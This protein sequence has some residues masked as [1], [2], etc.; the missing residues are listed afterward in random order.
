MSVVWEISLLCKQRCK[1]RIKIHITT[2]SKAILACQCFTITQKR[3]FLNNT[4]NA[5]QLLIASF[6]LFYSK[7]LQTSQLVKQH[8]RLP[9]FRHHITNFAWSVIS[10][11][12][13][14]L[15]LH[16]PL[17]V[18]ISQPFKEIRHKKLSQQIFAAFIVVLIRPVLHKFLLSISVPANLG[19]HITVHQSTVPSPPRSGLFTRRSVFVFSPRAELTPSFTSLSLFCFECWAEISSCAI[20]SSSQVSRF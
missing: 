12:V 6:L 20:T 4:L 3:S 17:I 19:Q 11:L 1:L 13:T 5:I 15:S 10:Q 9:R 7:F 16:R 14:T 18:N 2:I 8:K